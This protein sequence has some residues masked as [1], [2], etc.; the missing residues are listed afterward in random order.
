[1][2]RTRPNGTFSCLQN[3]G[4]RCQYAT[5]GDVRKNTMQSTAPE[6]DWHPS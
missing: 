4:C 2:G 3:P 6:Q 1:M 5:D